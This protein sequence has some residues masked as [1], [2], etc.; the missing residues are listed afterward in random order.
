MAECKQ[1]ANAWLGGPLALDLVIS[2]QA[3]RDKR[4]QSRVAGDADILLTPD[5]HCGNM[6]AKQLT[7]LREA[8]A[9]GIALD[10]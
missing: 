5:I 8:N 4:I 10:M 3:V 9:A 1:I 7:F 2:Q 6:F